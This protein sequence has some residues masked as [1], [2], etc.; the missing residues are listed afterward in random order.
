MVAREEVSNPITKTPIIPK[1]VEVV[2]GMS[3]I[4]DRAFATHRDNQ[5]NI[6]LVD[7]I[8]ARFLPSLTSEV[9]KYGVIGGRERTHEDQWHHRCNNRRW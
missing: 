3:L 9:I 5:A 1:N 2:A 4:M 7:T 6:L 8:D